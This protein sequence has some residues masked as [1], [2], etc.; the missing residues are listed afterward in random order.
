MAGTACQSNQGPASSQQQVSRVG[1]SLD[2]SM[3]SIL[4]GETV[5][6]VA[7]TEDT[8]G[9]DSKITWTS[10]SGELRTEQGGRVAR[11][12][13]DQPGKY[14]VVAVLG[15]DGQETRRETVEITVKPIA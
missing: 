8:Y 15:I 7:R 10:S 9:R 2:P 12:R 13:F 3:R 11:V 1:L 6:I 14:T 5:T 4:A